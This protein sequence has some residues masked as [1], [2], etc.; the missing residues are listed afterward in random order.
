MSAVVAFETPVEEWFNGEYAEIPERMRE[1]L[2][3]YIVDRVQPGDFLTA[4]ICNDLRNA[5]GRAD[6]ENLSLIP[7]YVRWFYN[8]A[9]NQS[10]G[11]LSR[12]NTWL[13][14]S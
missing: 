9:P 8:V 13:D 2:R 1:G 14:R 12:M 4:V 10:H 3:R 11:S 6:A 5:V 7:L